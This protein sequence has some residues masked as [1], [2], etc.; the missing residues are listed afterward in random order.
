MWTSC[1]HI[2]YYLHQ[3]FVILSLPQFFWSVFKLVKQ[4]LCRFIFCCSAIL[5]SH[6]ALFHCFDQSHVLISPFVPTLAFPL[7]SLAIDLFQTHQSI[8]SLS[9]L[10]ILFQW[11]VFM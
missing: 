5:S 1:S 4:S 3:I 6:W 2:C 11:D 7:M 8:I 10:A 9:L